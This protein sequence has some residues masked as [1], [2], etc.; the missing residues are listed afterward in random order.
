[1]FVFPTNYPS[2]AKQRAYQIIIII[3]TSVPSDEEK[4]EIKVER[5][6]DAIINITGHWSMMIC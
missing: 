1:M 6:K 3:T 2:E 4:E 5:I